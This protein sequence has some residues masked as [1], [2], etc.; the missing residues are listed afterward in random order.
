MPRLTTLASAGAACAIALVVTGAATQH[1]SAA[2]TDTAAAS[3]AGAAAPAVVTITARD[4]AFDAPD[5]VAAGLTT[6][7]LVNRGPELHH[8]QLIKLEEGRTMAD[9][10]AALKAGGPPPRWTRDVGG[11]NTP[12]PGGESEATL[13]LAPGR[14]A[15]LCFIPSPDGTPHVMKGM[16]R[17]IIAAA[18]RGVSARPAGAAAPATTMTLTDYRFGL[19]APLAAGTQTVRVRNAASQSHE[20]LFA[21]LAPGKTAADLAAWAEKPAGPPPG[22]PIGGTTGMAP[23][24]WNDVTLSLTPGEYALLCFIPDAKDG[25]PHIAHGMMQQITIR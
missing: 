18:P 14:Y 17:E 12:V 15:V 1:R 24:T 21:R 23:G 5:T 8:V 11:P 16:A 10:F 9:L 22:E 7:R 2:G 20:V 25:K 13:D 19:S 3:A 6:I 4:Y